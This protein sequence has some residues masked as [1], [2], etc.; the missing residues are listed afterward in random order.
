MPLDPARPFGGSA[1]VAAGLVTPGVLRGPRFRRL[2]PDVYVGARVE[3]DLALRARAAHLLVEGRGVVGGYAA[4]ELL[5]ASCGPDDA[6]VDIVLP[7]GAYRQRPGLVVHRGLLAPA[8][9]PP[10]TA[11]PSRPRSA[12]AT[13]WPAPA[14][15][16]RP[17]SRWTR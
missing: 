16:G 17:S 2:F 8:R 11:S 15:S 14:R 12:R 9:S 13:T 5:G 3:V 7:G 1:A 6:P 4:A 10:S